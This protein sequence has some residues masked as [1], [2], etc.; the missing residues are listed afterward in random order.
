M[1]PA[2]RVE[3]LLDEFNKESN[4]ISAERPDDIQVS[5]ATHCSND[6]T[7]VNVYNT[8]KNMIYNDM[9]TATFYRIIE[10]ALGIALASTF[11]AFV[12][13]LKSYAF[14]M[15]PLFWV[16]IGVCITFSRGLLDTHSKF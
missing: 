11:K 5:E 3:K 4:K 15:I 7:R 16:F 14:W 8:V 9:K 6:G 10:Q 12:V 1:P 13:S 2:M